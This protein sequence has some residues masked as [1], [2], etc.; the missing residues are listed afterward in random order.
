VTDVPD[1]MNWSQWTY[2]QA[3]RAVTDDDI[4]LRALSNVQWFVFNPAGVDQAGGHDEVGY[5]AHG[6]QYYGATIDHRAID[7]FEAGA[8]TLRTVSDELLTGV[9]GTVDLNTLARLRDRVIVLENFLSDY[10]GQ[11]RK[12]ANDLDSTAPGFSGKAAYL[13]YVRLAD[14]AARLELWSGGLPVTPG[15]PLS[16]AAE[17]ARSDLDNFCRGMAN[18]WYA[19]S[20][21]GVRD[22]IRN[23]V[24]AETWAIRNHLI[25]KGIVVGESGYKFDKWDPRRNPNRIVL[26]FMVDAFNDRVRAEVLAALASYP[27]G[28]LRKPETWTRINQSITDTVRDSLDNMDAVARQYIA[29]LGWAYRVLADGLKPLQTPV[30]FRPP[31]I[32]PPPPSGGPPPPLARSAAPPPTWG[33]GGGGASKKPSGGPGGGGGP[34]HAVPP[35]LELPAGGSPGGAPPVS[36]PPLDSGGPGH[37]DPAPGRN[38]AFPPAFVE[39][40][41]ATGPGGAADPDVTPGAD[42]A[43]PPGG[44]GMPAPIPPDRNS[45]AGAGAPAPPDGEPG[46]LPAADLPAAAVPGPIPPP[47]VSARS[48]GRRGG[49]RRQDDPAGGGAVAPDGQPGQAGQ[50]G[51]PG[52]QGDQPGSEEPAGGLVIQPTVEVPRAAA[53][54]VAEPGLPGGDGRVG[55]VGRVSPAAVGPPQVAAASPGPAAQPSY[56]G[57]YWPTGQY[58]PLSSQVAGSRVPRNGLGRMPFLL[59]SSGG[60]GRPY[61]RRAPLTEDEQVWSATSAAGDGVVGPDDDAHLDYDEPAALGNPG[62]ARHHAGT[63]SPAHLVVGRGDD[64]SEDQY[65]QAA[66]AATRKRFGDE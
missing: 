11:F 41:A 44:G 55:R 43:P 24:I 35:P 20:N 54:G 45:S 5:Q 15:V 62:D 14:M 1:T 48:S 59:G 19:E 39:N 12:R 50:A 37:P 53:A 42:A 57:A 46:G 8:D 56:R 47:A 33:G 60:R 16:K 25:S 3:L 7:G 32:S 52:G 10:A 63:G 21:T 40:A 64:Q 51:Q 28:D 2:A 17:N 49:K 22:R 26:P 61:G 9:R 4:D 18:A 34:A 30:P 36:P 29:P 58:G 6:N 66:E 27:K 13:I 31:P 23:A 65:D 38:G